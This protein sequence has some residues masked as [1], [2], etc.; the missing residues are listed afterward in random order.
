M[1]RAHSLNLYLIL[2]SIVFLLQGCTCGCAYNIDLP[3]LQSNE[4]SVTSNV[5]VMADGCGASDG[6]VSSNGMTSQV[7]STPGT[8]GYTNQGNWVM[9][10]SVSALSNNQMNI[11]TSGIIY[12][13]STG[14]DIKNTSFSTINV[15]PTAAS[16]TTVFSSGTE[17]AVTAGQMLVIQ[18]SGNLLIGNNLNAPSCGTAFNNYQSLTSGTCQG[19]NL[20]GL[21]IYVGDTE[22]VTLDGSSTLSA[23]PSSS[24]SKTSSAPPSVQMPIGSAPFY[25]SR[26]PTLYGFLTSQQLNGYVDSSQIQQPSLL[27]V[28]GTQY[29][30]SLTPAN[31]V[32][33]YAFVIPQ[34]VSGKLG[35][36]IAEGNYAGAANIASTISG[37]PNGYS[38]NVYS[39]P[40]ACL[41]QNSLAG[42]QP[43]M[44]GALQMYIGSANPNTIDN[45]STDFD[46]LN[47]DEIS[48]YYPEL[49]Q[50]IAQNA[51]VEISSD[52][53]ALSSLVVNPSPQIAPVVINNNNY[54]YTPSTS[55][56]IWFLVRDDYYNDNIGSYNVSVTSTTKKNSVVSSFMQ[57]LINPITN[58]LNNTTQLIYNNFYQSSDFLMMIRAMLTLYI[59]I[60]GVQFA[61]GLTR[62]STYDMVIRVIKIAILVELMSPT[63]WNFFNNYLFDLFTQ[64]SNSL[65]V[66]ATGDTS[67][68]KVNI[69]GF[70]DDAFNMFFQYSILERLIALIYMQSWLG[71]ICIGILIYVICVYT[72][73]MAQ[74]LITYL[75]CIVGTAILLSIAPF[76]IALLLFNKTKKY[77]DGWIKALADFAFQSVILLVVFW[78]ISTIFIQLWVATMSYNICWGG[79]LPIYMNFNMLT[80]FI[81]NDPALVIQLGCVQWFRL[82]ENY[83]E[84]VIQILCLLILMPAMRGI[85]AHV[86]AMMGELMGGMSSA[87]VVL[88]TA[89]G[90][91]SDAKRY[92][93]KAGNMA[94]G[95]GS[96]SEGGRTETVKRDNMKYLF[97]RNLGGEKK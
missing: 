83:Y 46:N 35:F 32:G 15:S 16:T 28:F 62:I 76:F 38:L 4:S 73:V 77:F 67:A 17:L 19:N 80:G 21:T 86:P 27:Q 61:L 14:V 94:V 10:P 22:L 49:A 79:V 60:F 18:G 53:D 91:E 82:T 95:K 30:T 68:Y 26:T 20:F 81:T 47:N 96:S 23:A 8:T 58:Q 85:V 34:G 50:Y 36:A 69:F 59:A 55:G 97:T 52:A 39:T 93:E 12:Y 63:S 66:M 56:N 40:P 1:L 72:L 65:I 89:I 51:G 13:C 5:T 44:R 48:L 84:V 9:L 64:G 7:C 42:N 33:S 54:N 70:V 41:V 24:S 2:F 88:S 31:G 29:N 25:M 57:D 92:M 45:I 90:M 3:S 37:Q 6:S 43:G 75:I 71:W 74:A 11:T 87:A 78:F